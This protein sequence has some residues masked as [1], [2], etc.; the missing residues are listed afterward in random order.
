VPE[1]D[2]SVM[3]VTATAANGATTISRA[4]VR[5]VS[6]TITEYIAPTATPYA[7]AVSIVSGTWKYDDEADQGLI[8]LERVTFRNGKL[9]DSTKPEITLTLKLSRGTWDTGLVGTPAPLAA[10]IPGGN[11]SNSGGVDTSG[12]TPSAAISGNTLTYT[13]SAVAADTAFIAVEAFLPD[14]PVLTGIVSAPAKTLVDHDYAFAETD[15]VQLTRDSQGVAGDKQIVVATGKKYVV[16]VDGKWRA[17]KA[18]GTLDAEKDSPDLAAAATA[19]LTGTAITGLDN[20]KVYDVYLLS[21]QLGDSNTVKAS[22][23][24]FNTG[25]FNAIVD[26]SGLA[27]PNTISVSAG[28]ATGGSLVFLTKDAIT[29]ITVAGAV[30]GN[31]SSGTEIEGTSIDYKFMAA[32]FVAGGATL[33]ATKV[34]D[35]F[36]ILETVGSTF[37]ATIKAKT[38]D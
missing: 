38:H 17:V 25:G 24:T 4:S 5:I 8:S 1:T 35:K 10:L 30:T 31:D 23:G 16:K 29:V 18:D 13:L 37:V 36:F 19:D 22:S 32:S 26:L 3:K 7:Y 20:S 33:V 2:K 27:N 34:N 9:A 11:V 14:E 28:A 12:Y 15:T 6:L 21:G